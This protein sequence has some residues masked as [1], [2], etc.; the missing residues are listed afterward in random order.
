MPFD[1]ILCRQNF[2]ILVIFLTFANK[3]NTQKDD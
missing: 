2:E 1:E 3:I